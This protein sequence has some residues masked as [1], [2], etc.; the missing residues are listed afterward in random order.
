M[1]SGSATASTTGPVR[2]SE[3]ASS[4]IITIIT[5]VTAICSGRSFQNGRPSRGLVD[6]VRGAHE[7]AGVA[8][9]RPQRDGQAEDEGE[10]GGAAGFGDRFDRP[11]EGF[12]RRFR[13]DF[14]DD[15]GQALGRRF[16]DR[17]RSDQR[18]HRDQR[19]EQRE[20]PVVGERRRPVGEVVLLELGRGALDRRPPAALR[21]GALGRVVAARAAGRSRDSTSDWVCSEAIEL[22]REQAA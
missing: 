6:D 19:R 4:V 13:A 18:D 3:T 1:P 2:T 20:Q 8:G 12:R 7:G 21:G 10:A 14:G 16:R 17:R 9:G 5:R 22:T 15:F 11:F